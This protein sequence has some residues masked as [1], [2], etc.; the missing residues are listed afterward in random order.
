MANAPIGR[1][2]SSHQPAIEPDASEIGGAEEKENLDPKRRRKRIS[3]S[4]CGGSRPN[5][6]EEA[7]QRAKP[8]H[9][10]GMDRKERHEG[11]GHEEGDNEERDERRGLKHEEIEQDDVPYGR[12]PDEI[13]LLGL[14]VEIRDMKQAGQQDGDGG[15]QTCAFRQK[16]R[17]G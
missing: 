7:T 1:Q 3:D 11:E 8:L 17:L 16:R 10:E 4:N 2:P 14:A 9:A 5:K 6:R 13:P 12:E 15:G